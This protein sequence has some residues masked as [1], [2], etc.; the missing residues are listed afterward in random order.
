MFAFL[1]FLAL[2]SFVSTIML[3]WIVLKLFPKIH[4]LDRPHKYG[5]KR[6]PIPYPGGIVFYIVFTLS[7]LIFFPLD[8][9]Y[10]GLLVAITL[11]VIVSFIDDRK[12]LSPRFRLVIQF[13]SATIIALSGIGI[14]TLTNPLGGSP[15]LLDQ[16]QWTFILGGHLMT[17]SLFSYLFTVLWIVLFINTLNWLDGIP[18]LVSG[19]SGIGFLV[20]FLLSLFLSMRTMVGADEILNAQKVAELAIIGVGACF[21]FVWFDFYPPKMIMGDTGSML[22]G[23][24]IAVLAIYSG[25][26]VATTF[27]VL[28]FPVF[29][30]LFVILRRLYQKKSPFAG[31]MGHFH[32]RLLRIVKSE[33]KTLFS[34]YLICA[35]FGFSALMLGSK[36]KF[37]IMVFLLLLSIAI[38]LWVIHREKTLFPK[39]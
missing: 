30:A 6:D 23:F 2:E 25:S 1:F 29:D 37:Y 26:K 11:L 22:L 36:E 14:E 7:I 10:I 12:G 34:M 18:G 16:V 8:S 15:L 9:K 21:A 35:L 27:L 13:L 19:I 28:G 38:E 33:R 3:S 17:F 5:L 24:M 39:E 32:H 20:V 4:L 31:D